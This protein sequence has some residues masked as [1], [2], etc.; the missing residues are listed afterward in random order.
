M[1]IGRVLS[2]IVATVY[3]VIAW[4]AGGMEM[5]LVCSWPLI[6]PLLCIWF[7][8]EL[9]SWGTTPWWLVAAGGWLVLLVF[10][11]LELIE[12]PKGTL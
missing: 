1:K 6:F 5:A 3:I 7:S 12:Y 10:L 9:G 11:T 8:E 2:S 4:Q